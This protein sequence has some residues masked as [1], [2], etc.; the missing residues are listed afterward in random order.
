[1]IDNGQGVDLSG[2]SDKSLVKLL[3]KLFSS[4][5]LEKDR[6]GVYVLPPKA[7]PT[8]DIM[9]SVLDQYINPK[10]PSDGEQ[11]NS[12]KG[13]QLISSKDEHL[14]NPKNMPEEEP[15]LAHRKRLSFILLMLYM[16]SY[17]LVC[18][19]SQHELIFSG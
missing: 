14:V 7:V 9:S 11:I 5:D 13:D 17:W 18:W 4:L 8:L 16:F 2:I 3:K 10:H 12:S 15:Q 6:T 1:M 19:F